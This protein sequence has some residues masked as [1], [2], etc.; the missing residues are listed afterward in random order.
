MQQTSMTGDDW[1]SDKDRKRQTAAQ[2]HLVNVSR[3]CASRMRTTAESLRKQYRAYIDAGHP[4]RQGDA[5]GR[6]RLAADLD[7]LAAFFEGVYEK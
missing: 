1:L 3:E 7:E 6:L 4:D 5:D 2:R